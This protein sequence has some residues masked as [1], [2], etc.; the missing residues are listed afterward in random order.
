M[1]NDPLATT[2]KW[3][4]A[5]RPIPGENQSGDGHLVVETADGWLLAV[6]DGLGHGRGAAEVRRTF[7]EVLRG[8]AE[9]PVTK[10]FRLGNEALRNTRGCVGSLVSIDRGK[11]MLTWFGVGNV[12]GVLLHRHGNGNGFSSEYI[13]T[14]GGVVGYRLPELLPASLRL[15]DNDILVL[16]T[17]GIKSGFIDWLDPALSPR[18]LADTILS[19]YAKPVDDALV[20]VARWNTPLP[21]ATEGLP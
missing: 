18:Q 9:E 4:V 14:R 11:G 6:V 21:Q 7:L 12:E 19:R 8:H 20:L 16:A 15:A 3:S 13:T 17:D 5:E 2:L 10:L 1:K